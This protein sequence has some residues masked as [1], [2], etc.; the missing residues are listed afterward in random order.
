MSDLLKQM[1][2]FVE[3]EA[4]HNR[5]AEGTKTTYLAGL[6]RFFAAA[7]IS[8]L[9]GVRELAE[10]GPRAVQ[11]IIKRLEK[12]YAP[13]TVSQTLVVARQFYK[14]L[15]IDEP[16]LKNPLADVSVPVPANSPEWNVLHEGDTKK[17]L[18]EIEDPRERAVI[19]TLVLQGWRVSEFC[20]MTWGNVRAKG[21]RYVVEWRAKGK[22]LRVQGLQ[23]AVLGAA[24]ELAGEKPTPKAPFIARDEFG[25]P[26]DRHR[27]YKIVRKYAAAAGF[28]LTPHGLRATYVSSVIDRKGIE[29]AR[30][31]AGHQSIATTQKYSR[32]KVERDDDLTVEDL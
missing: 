21:D 10:E 27:V 14:A 24:Q 6:A 28:R 32:W 7:E 22:K 13:S 25:R 16:E 18:K 26:Y 17:L 8:E 29:A 9:S 30:Q 19:L 20:R 3:K 11:R 23:P 5:A 12:D 15:A 1:E 4:V 31:L 2:A